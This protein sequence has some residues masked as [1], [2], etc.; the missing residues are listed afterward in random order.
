M[1]PDGSG[2]GCGFGHDRY[3]VYA[4]CHRYDQSIINLLLANRNN[5][6]SLYWTSGIVDFF[7]IVRGGYQ[8]APAK[9][10]I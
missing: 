8:T 4:G 6:D 1:A 7:N 10:C 5:Y 2:L 3:G 9:L